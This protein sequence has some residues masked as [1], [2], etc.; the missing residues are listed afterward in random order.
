ML[1]QRVGNIPRFAKR[2]R[3]M[4]C[5]KEAQ[6]TRNIGLSSGAHNYNKGLVI[7][8]PAAQ[9]VVFSG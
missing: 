5:R 3:I 4:F 9:M 1:A 8:K 7:R 6:A 2:G